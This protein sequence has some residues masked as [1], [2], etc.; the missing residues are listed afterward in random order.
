LDGYVIGGG[1][2]SGDNSHGVHQDLAVM[3]PGLSQQC[4]VDIEEEEWRS[5]GHHFRIAER[6]LL[7][8]L[9]FS[10]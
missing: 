7:D 2:E 8:L 5:G 4:A 9:S 1:G 10:Y 3:G 6:N